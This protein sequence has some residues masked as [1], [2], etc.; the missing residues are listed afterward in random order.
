MQRWE[1]GV[2]ER[3]MFAGD[4][5]S[6]GKKG[7]HTRQRGSGASMQKGTGSSVLRSRGSVARE[8]GWEERGDE[9]E[10]GVSGAGRKL[11]GKG[12]TARAGEGEERGL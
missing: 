1:E 10:V 2:R 11:M 9:D 12:R 7:I 5:I 8:R 3:G 4:A 6:L